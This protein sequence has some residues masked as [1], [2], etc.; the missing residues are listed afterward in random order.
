MRIV[1]ER[2]GGIAGRRMTATIDSATLDP[3]VAVELEGIVSA[4]RFFD[5]PAGPPA[6]GPGAD[7][8]QYRVTVERAGRRHTVET[9]DTA[10]AP[11]LRPLLMWL[12]RA[13]RRGLGGPS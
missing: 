3:A 6:P 2:S 8:F 10:A 12:D 1:F 5:Q 7:M 13:A 4:A 11:E 9:S